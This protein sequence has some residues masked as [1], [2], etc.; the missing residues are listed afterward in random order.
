MLDLNYYFKSRFYPFALKIS[1]EKLFVVD[2]N[3]VTVSA[4]ACVAP[5]PL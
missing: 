4:S 5:L 2:P 1:C 3:T